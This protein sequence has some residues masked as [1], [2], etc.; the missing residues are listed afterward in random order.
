VFQL[1]RR[2]LLKNPNLGITFKNFLAMG[3]CGNFSSEIFSRGMPV[4]VKAFG[5]EGT[6]GDIIDVSFKG[7]ID[8]ISILS[9]KR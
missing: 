9:V 5:P 1:L 4:H 3:G 8:R 2:F 7:N 6:L